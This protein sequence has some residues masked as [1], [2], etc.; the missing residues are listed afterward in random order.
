MIKLSFDEQ[1]E[2]VMTDLQAI[3]LR[4]FLISKYSMEKSKSDV[5]K[6]AEAVES[7]RLQ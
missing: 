7:A 6:A 2:V 5:V 3:E 4:D 1:Y